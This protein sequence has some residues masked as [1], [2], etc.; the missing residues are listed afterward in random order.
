MTLLG[1]GVCVCGFLR[2]ERSTVMVSW[3]LPGTRAPHLPK[4]AERGGCSLLWQPL[5]CVAALTVLMK[6]CSHLTAFILLERDGLKW[7]WHFPGSIRV[8]RSGW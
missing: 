5:L 7:R 1:F 8:F 2:T 4:A 3:G 6:M